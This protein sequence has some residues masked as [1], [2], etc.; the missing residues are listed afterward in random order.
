MRR[1]P[2]LWLQVTVLERRPDIGGVAALVRPS[3]YEFYSMTGV[4]E[5]VIE[6]PPLFPAETVVRGEGPRAER[7]FD[8]ISAPMAAILFDPAV[9]EV[10]VTREGLRIMRQAAEGGA[11][12]IFCCVR[13]YSITRRCQWIASSA[14]LRSSKPSAPCSGHLKA[15]A[16]GM[17]DKRPLNPYLVLA[18]AV[19]FAGRRACR[20]RPAAT[21]L[22]ICILLLIACAP[23]LAH[24]HAGSIVHR[25][26]GRR[27]LRLGALHSGCLSRRQSGLRALAAGPANLTRYTLRKFI[28]ATVESCPANCYEVISMSHK[29]KGTKISHV[30]DC[31]SFH[32]G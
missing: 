26:V 16:R 13:P 29:L 28:F 25:P 7:T 15:G 19:A 10:A 1:L 12:S 9:K 2:Q 17:N 14:R 5:H 21:W 3:G 32:K 11:A 30:R 4:F 27:P 23:H 8:L 24:D 20:Y 18:L 22:R 6:P 31:R